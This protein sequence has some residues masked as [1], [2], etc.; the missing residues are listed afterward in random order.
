[1]QWKTAL[2]LKIFTHNLSES[3]V[4]VYYGNLVARAWAV[5]LVL[6]SWLG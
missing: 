6:L 2:K 1:M 4:S 3:S 5:M